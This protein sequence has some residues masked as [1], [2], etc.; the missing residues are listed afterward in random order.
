MANHTGKFRGRFGLC[1]RNMVYCLSNDSNNFEFEKCG[2]RGDGGIVWIPRPIS[3][4][5]YNKY[6]VGMDL[7]DLRQLHCNSKIMGMN[8]LWLK[9]FFYL[10]DDVGTSNALVLFF[11]KQQKI[12]QRSCA[13]GLS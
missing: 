4:A 13:P 6:M 10:L 1:D 9:L 3:I 12:G 2:W 7:A 11:N 8:Q 5:Q